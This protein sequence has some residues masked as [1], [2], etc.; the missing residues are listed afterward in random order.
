[1]PGNHDR[2]TVRSFAS[3]RFEGTFGAFMPSLEFPWVRHLSGDVAILGLDPTRPDI[4]ARGKLPPDQLLK[5]RALTADRAALPRHLIVA[6]HY[7]VA[8][9]VRYQREL[10]NKR[11]ENDEQVRTWL[12]G[13]GPHL[14]C[15]GHVHAAWVFQPRSLPDQICINAGAPLMR[16]PT[17]LRL[18]GFM[19][20]VLEEET[21][22]VTHHAWTGT[23]WECVPMLQPATPLASVAA[24][25]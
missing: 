21:V 18:P 6:C 20:I 16:D 12:A 8:A 2:T 22:A 14:Y 13:I 9:P 25:T 23:G 17:G 5:A 11:L 1:V 19:E 24:A 7:P 3:R 4:A 10:F 15:C